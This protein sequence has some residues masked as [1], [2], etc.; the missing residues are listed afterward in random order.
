MKI[1]LKTVR[2]GLESETELVYEEGLQE[3]NDMINDLF[4]GLSIFLNFG[5]IESFTI[6][7]KK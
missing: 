1:I 2:K 7:Y 4:D 3:G 5:V 6:T